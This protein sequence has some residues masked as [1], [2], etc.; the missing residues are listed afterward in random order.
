MA[1]T[2]RRVFM[3][4]LM[5]IALV[6]V[7]AQTPWKRSSLPTTPTNDDFTINQTDQHATNH[8]IAVVRPAAKPIVNTFAIA[9]VPF[10]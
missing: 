10:I 9:S 7:S 2:L 4:I 8:A 3:I 5:G 6:P 1:P